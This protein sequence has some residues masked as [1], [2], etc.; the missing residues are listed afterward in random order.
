MCRYAKDLP[1]LLHIMAGD[2]A[3]KLRLNEP[4]FTK[5][6][7]VGIFFRFI[8]KIILYFGNYL[9]ILTT[10]QFNFKLNLEFYF[11]TILKKKKKTL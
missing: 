3:S 10:H 11:C 6:I 9:D 4:L 7:K 8:E 5:D 1:T 2:K